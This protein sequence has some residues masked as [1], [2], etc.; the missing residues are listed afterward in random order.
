M[1]GELD[2]NETRLDKIVN[3]QSNLN[4]KLIDLTNVAEEIASSLLGAMGKCDDSDGEKDI[5]PGY[6]GGMEDQ[7]DTSFAI[8]DRLSNELNRLKEIT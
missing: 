8:V 5:R 4:C 7:I 6:I 1:E 2:R 3:R